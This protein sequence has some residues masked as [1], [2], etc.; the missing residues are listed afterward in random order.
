MQE[1]TSSKRL[2][3]AIIIFALLS[4][5]PW[6]DGYFFLLDFVSIPE[7]VYSDRLFWYTGILPAITFVI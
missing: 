2:N 5:Y 7:D 3:I 6:R 4:V 1:I